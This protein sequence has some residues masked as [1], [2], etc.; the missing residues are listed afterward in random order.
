MIT[1]R[2]IEYAALAGRLRI[3]VLTVSMITSFLLGYIVGVW[4]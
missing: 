4:R 1:E 3:L 2:E